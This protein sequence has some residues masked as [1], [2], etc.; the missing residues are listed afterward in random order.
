MA[1]GCPSAQLSRRGS[2]FWDPPH[3]RPHVL[4]QTGR[5]NNAPLLSTVHSGEAGVGVLPGK[6]SGRSSSVAYKCREHAT[7]EGER[8]PAV[9]PMPV[10]FWG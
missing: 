9:Q 7:V 5:C 4:G 8:S 6:L 3:W 10:S 2:G 1:A